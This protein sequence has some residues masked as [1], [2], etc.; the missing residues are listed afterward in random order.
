[1]Q[2]LLLALWKGESERESQIQ[3]KV[4]FTCDCDDNVELPR[5]LLQIVEERERITMSLHTPRRP[6]RFASIVSVARPFLS[7]ILHQQ[8]ISLYRLDGPSVGLPTF[9]K[10][11]GSFF[12]MVLLENL[13]SNH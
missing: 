11:A 9:A 3:W 8:R 5:T 1:M 7:E 2:I 13:F 6:E 10:R 4:D 12:S